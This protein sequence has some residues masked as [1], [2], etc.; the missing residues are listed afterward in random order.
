MASS[1]SIS[2]TVSPQFGRKSEQYCR[3]LNGET[4]FVYN[5]CIKDVQWDEEIPSPVLRVLCSD[6]LQCR[7]FIQCLY[8]VPKHTNGKTNPSPNKKWPFFRIQVSKGTAVYGQHF[9]LCPYNETVIPLT[10]AFPLSVWK[11]CCMSQCR[12]ADVNIKLG[13]PHIQKV[14][15][16]IKTEQLFLFCL[17]QI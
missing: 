16:S 2:G 8:F 14:P 17:T 13:F 11:S 15:P 4:R 9:S 5:L 1:L 3:K 12:M 7:V 6:L 10:L